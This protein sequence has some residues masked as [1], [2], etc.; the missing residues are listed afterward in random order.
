[1]TAETLVFERLKDCAFIIATA[2][3]V[4]EPVPQVDAPGAP[5]VDRPGDRPA[6]QVMGDREQAAVDR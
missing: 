4:P 3:L 5:V 1:M 6:N 2:L